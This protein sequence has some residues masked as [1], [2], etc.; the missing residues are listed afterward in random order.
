[1]SLLIFG[2]IISDKHIPEILIDRKA[3]NY[4]EK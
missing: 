4:L 2:K 1:M 3:R